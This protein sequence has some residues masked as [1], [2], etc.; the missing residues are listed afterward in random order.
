MKKLAVL[1][2]AMIASTPLPAL[3]DTSTP[4]LDPN[5]VICRTERATGSR[6]ALSR[7]CA[8]RA[9]WLEDRRQQQAQAQERQQRQINPTCM[10]SAERL[11]SA[12]RYA[13]SGMSGR[14]AY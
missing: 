9:Q 7:R 1:T 10:T 14:C 2:F 13:S 4:Q 6:V 5:E 3:A 11:R 8:T 12:G